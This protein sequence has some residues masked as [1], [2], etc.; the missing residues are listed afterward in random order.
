MICSF[1]VSLP[2]RQFVIFLVALW[3][4]WSLRLVAGASAKMAVASS[5]RTPKDREN[6]SDELHVEVGYSKVLVLHERI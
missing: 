6:S 1:H 2:F 5:A 4:E 3:R